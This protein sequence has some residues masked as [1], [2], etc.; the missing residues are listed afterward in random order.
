[1]EDNFSEILLRFDAMG[2]GS[3]RPAVRAS[4]N[5]A[6][7]FSGPMP[8]GP[9]IPDSQATDIGAN[10]ADKFQQAFDNL[11]SGS[12]FGAVFVSPEFVTFLC[13]PGLLSISDGCQKIPWGS[14]N[15]LPWLSV[16]SILLKQK[17]RPVWVRK[18]LRMSIASILFHDGDDDVHGS[19]TPDGEQLDKIL[20]CW[21]VYSRNAHSHPFIAVIKAAECPVDDSVPRWSVFSSAD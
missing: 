6:G 13:P 11:V 4:P 17:S 3:P 5:A 15:S 1:M 2:A 16:W 9:T 20:A 21:L 18:L 14:V 12:D 7:M 8:T 10:G 19:L